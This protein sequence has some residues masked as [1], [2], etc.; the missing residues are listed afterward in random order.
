MP[1]HFIGVDGEGV[2]DS[3][4]THRYVM[5]SVGSQTL[6]V[7]DETST[8]SFH[9]IMPFLWDQYLAHPNSTFVGFYLGYD[10]SQWFK[11]LPEERARMLFTREGIRLRTPSSPHMHGRTFPVNYAGWDFDIMGMRRF[12]L[13]KPGSGQW[14]YICDAG[15]FWQSSLMKAIDKD[16]WTADPILTDAEYKIIEQGKAARATA[17]LT[18]AMEKYNTT[19][20]H[21]LAQI[22]TRLA[23]GFETQGWKLKRTQWFGPG[24]AAQVWLNSIKAPTSEQV[25]N[26]TPPAVTDA[27]I[28]S[29]Y[30]GRFEIVRHGHVPGISHEYDINSA[31]PHIISTLPCLLHGYWDNSGD[32]PTLMHV[33]T[34]GRDPLLGGLPHRDKDGIIAYPR[35]VTGWY[36]QHEL[37]AAIRA[38]LVSTYRVETKP[39]TYNRTCQCPPPMASIADLYTERL[40]VGKNTSQGKAL[41]L[42]YNSAYGKFA[43]SIGSPKYANPIYASLITSGCR[44]MIL[45][46]IA[47]HPT[48]TDD[49]LMIATDG[50]YFATPHNN[51]PL[52]S[53]KL[54]AWDTDI[55]RNLTL[56]MPGVYW[57]DKARSTLPVL[58]SRGINATELAKH[59]DWLDLQFRKFTEYPEWPTCTLPVQFNVTSPLVAL[60]RGKWSECGKVTT[61]EHNDIVRELNSD[62]SNKRVAASWHMRNG[63]LTTLPYDDLGENHPYDKRFGFL[64]E[65]LRND[66]SYMTD[67]GS[68]QT[69]L[70]ELL[71]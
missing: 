60:A 9:E 37:N 59:L 32:G 55:K 39:W 19:E 40:K 4:G 7:K 18:Q 17:T 47:T 29:Y 49:L 63:L 70:M 28:A 14:L 62:P 46:A 65:S 61:F 50:I 3:D 16:S 64:L 12:R 48:G 38:G 36:W 6:R 1:I 44:T 53:T 13:S 66:D 26:A 43:Q 57:D 30:G 54:G 41:K 67:E 21:A 20:N 23:H 45:D 2:T 56:F 22:M 11:G 34:T 68:L 31:Y 58:K 33:T 8:L 5:L 71:K 51:L 10:F 25:F 52:D 35:N 15:A 69:E 27:A 42:V 24:Q